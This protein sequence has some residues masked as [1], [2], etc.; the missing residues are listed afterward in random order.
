MPR[1]IRSRLLLSLG[2][3]LTLGVAV[4][5][6]PEDAPSAP[7]KQAIDR[8]VTYLKKR[9]KEER[10]PPTWTPT[11]Q[12][13]MEALAGL[14]LLECGVPATD[15]TVQATAKRVRDASPKLTNTYELTTAIWFLHRLNGDHDAERIRSMALRLVTGQSLDGG[16]GYKCRMLT[17]REEEQLLGLLRDADTKKTPPASDSAPAHLPV[18][19]FRADRPF[20]LKRIAY[21]D[22]SA[23]QFALLG[24]WAACEQG[25][26]VSR[27]LTFAE[28]RFR[29]T[30][31]TE[32]GWGYSPTQGERVD[33]MT[34]AGLVGL[35]AG[36]TVR[37]AKAPVDPVANRALQL[38]GDTIGRGTPWDAARRKASQL[39]AAP[40][41]HRLGQWF[42]I[43]GQG[44]L[45][46]SKGEPLFERERELTPAQRIDLA[47]LKS[48]GT[49]LRRRLNAIHPSGNSFTGGLFAARAWGDLYYLWSLERVGVV[50]GL[51]TIGDRDWYAWGSTLIL[52]AQHD[53][54]GWADAF[55]GIP[56]TCFALLFL[57]RA[58]P[59]GDLAG[60]FQGLGPFVDPGPRGSATRP[61]SPSGS[62]S[63]SPR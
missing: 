12:T 48:Q 17:A 39:Y 11:Y 55:P 7:I 37:E 13:G 31:N 18:F 47:A 32:G 4:A 33:S 61:V 20:V 46:Q 6:P 57:R 58:A 9:L 1:H 34:C 43:L 54:G 29:A 2:T 36:R 8:G 63:E 52:A 44:H 53:D 60:K 22:N 30:V 25:V 56:D 38:L 24:L 21:D 10:K 59:V 26:P 45:V 23:T 40:V 15:E 42:T 49:E 27:S 35:A 14:T 19:R 5:A 41:V 51:K 28:A 3:F 62:S 16:W 50:Y